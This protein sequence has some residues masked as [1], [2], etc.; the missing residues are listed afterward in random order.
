MTT[1]TNEARRV[2]L[3]CLVNLMSE[4]KQVRAAAETTEQQFHSVPGNIIMSTRV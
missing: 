4:D 2:L 3:E 1:N